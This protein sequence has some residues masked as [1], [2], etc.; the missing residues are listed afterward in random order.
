LKALTNTLGVTTDRNTALLKWAVLLHG[1][2]Y[3]IWSTSALNI[4]IGGFNN[5]VHCLAK[6]MN[7]FIAAS[8]FVKEE[9]KEIEMGRTNELNGGM[10]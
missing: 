6:C 8:E 3:H 9:M 7:V 1:A 10:T 4:S 5:N 2:S